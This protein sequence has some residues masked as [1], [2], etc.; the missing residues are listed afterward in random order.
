[1]LSGQFFGDGYVHTDGSVYVVMGDSSKGLLLYKG[2]SPFGLPDW[3]LRK[4][5]LTAGQMPSNT[6]TITVARFGGKVLYKVAGLT[7]NYYEG[8][9]NP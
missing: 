7:T 1:M 3:A 5:L 4:T 9:F 2:V 6:N 8:A